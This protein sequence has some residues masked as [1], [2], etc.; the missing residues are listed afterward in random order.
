MKKLLLSAVTLLLFTGCVII[1]KGGYKSLPTSRTFHAGF[2]KV[3]GVL[4]SEISAFAVIKTI[5][6]ASAHVRDSF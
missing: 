3:W 2:D 4:V 5:D 1:P 6:K